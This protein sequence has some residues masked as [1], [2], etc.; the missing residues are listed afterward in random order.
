[1]QTVVDEVTVMTLGEVVGTIEL[2]WCPFVWSPCG[3][4]MTHFLELVWRK[5]MFGTQSKSRCDL[6]MEDLDGS[7][8]FFLFLD[9]RRIR[10]Y[11]LLLGAAFAAREGGGILD[12]AKSDLQNMFCMKFA[13]LKPR[14]MIV[15]MHREFI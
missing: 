10:L 3:L 2:N 8:A 12:C 1:M 7:F 4:S 15:L 11:G 13:I 14:N 9:F 5:W 6:L